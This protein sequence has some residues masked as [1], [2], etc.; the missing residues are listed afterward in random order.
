MTNATYKKTKIFKDKKGY[1]V[2][3]KTFSTLD[4]ATAHINYLH[5]KAIIKL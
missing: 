5:F 4:G 2:D 1:H 3:G